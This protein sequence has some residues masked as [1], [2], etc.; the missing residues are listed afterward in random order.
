M[1]SYFENKSIA[2]VGPASYLQLIS[3][4]NL[5]KIN[6]NDV[7]VR[8]NCGFNLQK[9]YPEVLGKRADFLYNTLLDDCING[10]V[11][12]V[13]EIAKSGIKHI[14]TIPKSD[15]K[16]IAVNNETNVSKEETYKKLLSLQKEHS[17]STSV[18]DYKFFNSISEKVDCRPTTGFVAIYDILNFNPKSLYVCGFSFYLGGVLK[19]YWGADKPGGILETRHR[20]E[21]EEAERAFNSTRH[22]HKNIWNYA[23]STLSTNEKITCDEIMTQI[24]NFESYDRKS[25]N[26]LIESYKN[27]AAY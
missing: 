20:S 7:V 23:K 10:G 1:K 13:E 9:E 18:I 12:N 2:L 4:N 27:A 25:Y 3:S 22:V 19:G 8:I 6:E 11:I 14:R 26:S 17:I 24:L 15:L 21:E 5:K 16:G